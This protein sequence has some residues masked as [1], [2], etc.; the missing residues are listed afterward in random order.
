MPWR[1]LLRCRQT[2]PIGG[3]CCSAPFRR[4]GL[5]PNYARLAAMFFCAA[6]VV[7][8]YTAAV[9][10]GVDRHCA[11]QRCRGGTP[12]LVGQSLHDL[13]GYVSAQR[14][15]FGG[16]Y[17]WHDGI[18]QQRTFCFLC[19]PHSATQ[20]QLWRPVRHRGQPLPTKCETTKMRSGNWTPWSNLPIPANMTS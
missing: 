14:R 15:G 10:V 13:I 16:R 18:R 2:G 5:S 12:G 4:L 19:G 8:I 3:G 20:A 1:R 11:D 9:Q 17:R 6:L 7:P